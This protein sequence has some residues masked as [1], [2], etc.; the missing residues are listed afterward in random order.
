MSP[1]TTNMGA[2]HRIPNTMARGVNEKSHPRPQ[3]GKFIALARRAEIGRS[4][5]WAVTRTAMLERRK[6]VLCLPELI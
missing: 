6:W 5:A 1:A 4:K 2:V 3:F